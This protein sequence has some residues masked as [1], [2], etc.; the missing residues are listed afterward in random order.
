[1]SKRRNLKI[2]ELALD[3]W[4]DNNKDTKL[5][6]NERYF[7]FKNMT[8][9]ALAD[10]IERIPVQIENYVRRILSRRPVFCTEFTNL[11]KIPRRNGSAGDRSI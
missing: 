10:G 11:C 9:A 7:F 5:K 8:V 1:M 2:V 6:G 3:E 4:I